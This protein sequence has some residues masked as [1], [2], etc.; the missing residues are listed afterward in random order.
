MVKIVNVLK[1]TIVKIIFLGLVVAGLIY[2]IIAQTEEDKGEV[3]AIVGEEIVYKTDIQERLDVMFRGADA[4]QMPKIEEFPKETIMALSKE[5]ATIKIVDK[6]VEEAGFYKDEEIIS[7]VKSHRDNLAREKF[8]NE[9][10]AKKVTESNV[11]AK[12]DELVK[13][14]EGREEIKVSHILVKDEDKAKRILRSVRLNNNDKYFANIAERESIDTVSAKNGGDLGYV[15][16]EQLVKEFSDVAF[17]LKK[18]SIAKKPVK[19]RYGWHIIKVQDRRLAQVA[20]YEQVREG[21]KQKLDMEAAR[22]Y[23]NSISSELNVEL[24]GKLSEAKAIK[25]APQEEV[26]VEA[27]SEVEKATEVTET[28]K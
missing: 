28:A 18:D 12:Y 26:E 21:I 2:G 24:V 11:R 1:S 6:K 20:P 4:S 22:D 23:V 25:S 3:V 27:V 9:L 17:L 14:L 10:M 19:T 13:S 8:M 5:I 7:K 16:R 15:L